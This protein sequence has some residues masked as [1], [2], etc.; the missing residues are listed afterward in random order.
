M[1]SAKKMELFSANPKVIDFKAPPL[2]KKV[3]SIRAKV[4]AVD[5]LDA[6]PTYEAVSIRGVLRQRWLEE[7]LKISDNLRMARK[8]KAPHIPIWLNLHLKV[9]ADSNVQVRSSTSSVAFLLLS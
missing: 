7:N 2:L 5:E 3:S 1:F 6:I 4:Y 8:T 9:S